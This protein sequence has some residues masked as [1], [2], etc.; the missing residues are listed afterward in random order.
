M[1]EDLGELEMMDVVG[2]TIVLMR[3]VLTC[4]LSFSF[5]FIV[6]FFLFG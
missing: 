4:R 5:P 6:S 1:S 2:G 3:A